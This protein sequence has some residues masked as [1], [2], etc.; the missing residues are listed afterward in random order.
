[1]NTIATSDYNFIYSHLCDTQE[2]PKI[3]S[4]FEWV[5]PYHLIGKKSVPCQHN[6]I[7]GMFRNNKKILSLLNKQKD[8]VAF[9]EF[10]HERY[11]NLWLKT[12]ENQEE[13][14]CNLKNSNLF[15]CEGQTSFLA[16]AFYNKKYS[17]TMTDFQDLECV[18]NSIYSEYVKSS[19]IIYNSDIKL[20]TLLDNKIEVHHNKKVKY[21]HQ[22]ISDLC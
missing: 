7:A 18:V 3:K 1:V 4:N 20:E 5:R 12:I 17:L 13:Y 15:V 14:F 2:P 22:K 6:V 21:L 16:D 9:T 8:C 11:D 10:P 19:S